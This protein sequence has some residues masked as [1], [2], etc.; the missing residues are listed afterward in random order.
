MADRS[1]NLADAQYGRTHIPVLSGVFQY[2][3][4]R[5][6]TLAVP[7]SAEVEVIESAF[8]DEWA[9]LGGRVLNSSGAGDEYERSLRRRL[10]RK[11]GKVAYTPYQGL[12]G[13]EAEVEVDIPLIVYGLESAL[14]YLGTPYQMH[15]L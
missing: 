5:Q 3:M 7:E 6:L 15:N 13:A 4:R 10:S 14:P 9:K 1:G 8:G 12:K 11:F 2:L